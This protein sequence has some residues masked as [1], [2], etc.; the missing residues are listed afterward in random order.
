[1]K[2]KQTS[3]KAD[4]VLEGGG[5]KGIGLVGAMT[6]LQEQGYEFG[7]IAG[8]S[9]GSIVGSLIAAGMTPQ[10]M[11]KAMKE[12]EWLRFADKGFVD[13]FGLPGKAISLYTELGVYEGKYVVSWLESFLEQY[14]VRTFADLKLTDDWAK[15]LPPEQRYKFVTI[16]TDVTR[17][18]LVRLPWDYHLYGLDPDTQSVAQAVRA[19]MSIPF[20]YEPAKIGGSNMVDGGML[21]NFPMN[22]FDSTP[23]WPTFGIKLSAKLEPD[24]VMNPSDSPLSFARSIL[25]TI[26]SAHDNQ[27]IDDPDVLKRVMFVDTTGVKSTNFNITP[28][29]QDWLYENGRTSATKFLKTWKGE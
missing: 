11:A 4:L 18:R 23:D 3:K 24:Q 26:T 21:S 17:G 10:D 13:R 8:T 5:V 6:V 15:D 1:M 2:T 25:G 19:S 29:Q 12:V 20:Y 9:A 27:H 28:E 14:G 16:V 22:L 7:R